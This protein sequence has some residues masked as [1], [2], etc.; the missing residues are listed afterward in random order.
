MKIDKK[1]K[2]YVFGA[3]ILSQLLIWNILNQND[4]SIFTLPANA[5]EFGEHNSWGA[6]INS[7]DKSISFKL[8][9]F[10]D[11]KKV[12]AIVI[13]KEKPAHFQFFEL[14]NVGRGIFKKDKIS[15]NFV[16]E[17]DKYKYLIVNKDDNYVL[18][19]DPYSFKQEELDGA[20]TIYDHSK[21][22]WKNDEK[23]KINKNRISRLANKQNGLKTPREARIFEISP[24]SFTEQSSYD[25]VKSKLKYIKSLGF[26]TIE[27]MHIENTYS[28][29]W[30]Y[31]GVDKHAPSQYLGGPDKLKEL[32]DA[33]HGEGM[34]VVFDVVPNHHGPDG[35]HLRK[36]GPYT[37]GTTD[38]GDAYNYNGKDY[39]YVRDYIINA[40]LGW[41]ENYHVD[42]F[43]LDMTKEMR[44]DYTLKQIAAEMNYHYPEVF[45][46]AEDARGGVKVDGSKNYWE[47]SLEAHDQRVINPL[48][49]EEYGKGLSQKEHAKKIQDII[50]HRVSIA[51]LGMDLEWD[52]YLYH[53]IDNSLQQEITYDAE[54]IYAILCSQDRLKYLDSHDEVGNKDGIRKITEIVCKKLELQNKIKLNIIDYIHAMQLFKHE[55][56]MWNHRR[57]VWTMHDAIDKIKQQKADL[58]CETLLIYLQ[59]GRLEKYYKNPETTIK[60]EKR[61]QLKFQN[62]ILSPLGIKKDSN[63]TI[64]NV[65]ATFKETCDRYKLATA[66]LFGIP[67]AK[68]VFQG[69]EDLD[70]TPF[71]FFRELK[72]EDSEDDSYMEQNYTKE[73]KDVIRKILKIEINEKK[74]EQNT[75][76]LAKDIFS[77]PAVLSAKL[78]KS[79]NRF[80]ESAREY[81]RGYKQG[82]DALLASTIG[83]INYSKKAQELMNEFAL[84]IKDLNKINEENSALKYG[85]IDPS[86]IISHKGVGILGFNSIYKDNEIFVLANFGTNNYKKGNHG[87]SYI[88]LPK[89]RWVEIMN[90]DNKK[91][92]GSGQYTNPEIVTS[93]DETEIPVNLSQNSVIY[94]KRVN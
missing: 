71:R 24:D 50:N 44:S 6:R 10:P 67:G 70:L 37:K 49:G 88:K 23:W 77:N 90:T 63:I 35:N 20:S 14:D 55:E 52:F 17:G 86:T 18:I 5:K 58:T 76:K 12:F 3:C 13:D 19:K 36:S 85:Y 53:K 1:V 27:I 72:S 89:G 7:L 62:E 92:G 34:N 46:I 81:E 91:Y 40:F 41:A 74:E 75:L 11:A 65:E 94:F 66:V 48:M 69:C 8:F 38:W 28:Y 87:D 16:K 21:F 26:N 51:N 93:N 39:E 61:L 73:E 32:V 9:T 59:T 54:V 82:K 22:K 56:Q 25:G 64:E 57:T 80:C 45:L 47:D 43:R 79:K 60:E 68:M 83:K 29:N 2:V 30:G 78:C 15:S 33:I 4:V 84:N 31:D 42:G